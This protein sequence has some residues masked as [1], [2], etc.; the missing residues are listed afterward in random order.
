MIHRAPFGSLERFVA[1]LIE[2]CA[3]NFP[4]WLIPDQAII[5][6]ISDKYNSYA[7]SLVKEFANY[8]IR[9][10]VDDRSEKTG[11]KIRDAEMKKIPYI[12]IVGENE[13]NTSSV[14]VRKH[15]GIDLGVMSKTDF[16][17]LIQ[18]EVEKKL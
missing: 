14:S 9:A 12:L 5:L 2:N 1:V 7:D 6:P 16:V 13:E 10:F 11:R 17:K 15:G 8:D 3:G 4:L 18:E